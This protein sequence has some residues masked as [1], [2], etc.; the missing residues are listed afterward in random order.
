MTSLPVSPQAP[1]SPQA[2]PELRAA[3]PVP[4][5]TPAAAHGGDPVRRGTE[6]QRFRGVAEAF[7]A[8]PVQRA[9]SASASA[10]GSAPAVAAT[11]TTPAAVPLGGAGHQDAPV[12]P[13]RSAGSPAA[14]APAALPVQRAPGTPPPPALAKPSRPAPPQLSPVTVHA[15]GAGGSGG[16][17]PPPYTEYAASPPPYTPP[18]RPAASNVNN[19]PRCDGS[20]DDTGSRFDA[21]ELSDGQVD[22]LTHR[23]IGPIT[24]LL[25]TELRMDRER[26]GRL[27]DPR[28]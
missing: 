13:L 8:L 12:V 23:L 6:G 21:R 1:L 28:R 27:R 22:E 4:G 17:P 11:V 25:R 18:A 9:A 14:A 3:Q 16:A 24:R 20:T 2:S 7:P 5:Q 10:S 26:I 15:A 19:G